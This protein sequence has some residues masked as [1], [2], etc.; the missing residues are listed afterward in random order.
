[1]NKEN[2]FVTMNDGE[3]IALHTWIPSGEVKTIIQISHGM[4]EYALRYDRF[5]EFVGK[6]GI[7]V[8]AHDHRGHGDTAKNDEEL[9]ILAK[10]DGFNRV[11]EDLHAMILKCKKD[12]PNARMIL[13]GHSFGSF[14]AQAFIERY[15]EELDGCILSGTAGPNNAINRGGK[16]IASIVC[17]LKGYAYKSSFLAN[18]SFGKY[19]DKIDIKKTE[20]DWLSRDEDEVK[21]YIDSKYCGFPASASFFR[22]ITAGLLAVHKAKA[23][24]N[25]P[26]KLP[27]YF[28]AGEADPVG[29]YTNTVKK[30]IEVYKQNGIENVQHSFYPG[31]RHEL[32][33]E[34]NRIEVMNDIL[35]WIESFTS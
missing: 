20:Y 19:N 11:V 17:A 2:V 7:A 15:G 22:D 9:G 4:Q 31:A 26:K 35:H 24:A 12:F 10:K 21:K 3:K 25:I 6:S 34:T 23:I 29:D 1:M 28:I 32:L 30:L 14:V 13:L 16:V 33:N 27:I 8:Y 18:A 5:A